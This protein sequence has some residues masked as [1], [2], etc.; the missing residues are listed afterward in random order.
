MSL[1]T[2]NLSAIHWVLAHLLWLGRVS[3]CYQGEASRII[4]PNE[5][6]IWL[7]EGK[8]LHLSGM[9]G[10]YGPNLVTHNSVS[11]RFCLEPH[12]S[13]A[14]PPVGVRIMDLS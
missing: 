9:Q 5:T 12:L 13:K 2:P 3:G 7:C 8:A 1:G 6:K 11:L 14:G 10:K 4:R